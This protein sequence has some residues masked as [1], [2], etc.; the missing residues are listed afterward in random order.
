[1]KNR[2][3]FILLAVTVFVHFIFLMNKQYVVYYEGKY[4]FNY[5][6]YREFVKE[7]NN[8]VMIQN[9]DILF[10]GVF[11]EWVIN[12]I[13]IPYL[14]TAILFILQYIPKKETNET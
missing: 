3:L 5:S 9:T 11:H 14:A 8:P 4:T 13:Y 2:F 1:M 12:F 6:Q 7:C 10:F